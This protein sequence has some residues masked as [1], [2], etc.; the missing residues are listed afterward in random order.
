M[1][2]FLVTK[3]VRYSC[4]P[5]DGVYCDDDYLMFLGLSTVNQL[6]AWFIVRKNM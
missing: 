1:T 3:K 4:E 5:A 2:S 6:T